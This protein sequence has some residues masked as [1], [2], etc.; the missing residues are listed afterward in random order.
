MLPVHNEADIIEE[1]LEHLISEGLNLVVLDNGSTDGTF[2]KCKKFAQRDVIKLE[3]FK[4]DTF[5]KKFD[6]ILRALYDMTL[7]HAPDWVIRADSD[8]FL[9]SGI[10]GLTLKEAI[11]QADSEGYNLIQFNRFD[12]F[13]TDN[14]DE[15]AKSIR[16]KLRYYSAYGDFVYR[17]W[18]Y[19]PGIRI[20]DSGGHY[21]IFPDNV[22]YKIS[23]K[24]FVMRHYPFRNKK[25]TEKKIQSKTRGIN[26]KT[27]EGLAPYTLKMLEGNFGKTVDHNSLTKYEE[28]GK[29]NLELKYIPK[30]ADIPPTKDEV[31]TKDGKL[32]IRSK[33]IRELQLELSELRR[34]SLE[35]KFRNKVHSAKKTIRKKL[36]K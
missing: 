11:N 26:S 6:L 23:P 4:T 10:K 3:Q 9:E 14:D 13:M 27:K 8:E 2:E 31:F 16:D 15:T 33:S 30:T 29:W 1:V 5:D 21:P 12:F 20:G 7:V 19:Y 24:K 36:G 22:R 35:F 32:K 34:K 25:Q 28:D 18:K 17:A